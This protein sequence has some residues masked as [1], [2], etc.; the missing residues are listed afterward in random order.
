LTPRGGIVAAAPSRARFGAYRRV[1]L[2]GAIL[3]VVLLALTP[4]AQPELPL[5]TDRALAAA[6][7]TVG[8]EST[9][10]SVPFQLE[11]APSFWGKVFVASPGVSSECNFDGQEPFANYDTCRIEFATE[12]LVRLRARP[13]PGSRFV[14]WDDSRCPRSPTCWLTINQDVP[15]RAIFDP[16]PFRVY[17][18]NL[19]FD[20]FVLSKPA[21]IRC[22]PDC[23]SAFPA[24]TR[25]ILN[26]F[27]PTNVTWGMGCAL[28]QR[29]DTSTTCVA[30]ANSYFVSVGLNGAIPP[31]VPFVLSVRFRVYRTGGGRVTG[32]GINCGGDCRETYAWGE[33]VR[34]TARPASGWRFIRWRG[35]CGRRLQCRVV[36]G[37]IVSIRAAFGRR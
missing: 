27:P 17:T 26:A 32:R 24:G 12:A 2:S 13:S 4:S 1:R 36:P 19:G 25:I 15:I 35:A 5:A 18:A 33:A 11:V 22:P 30:P 14:A 28:V 37:E 10:S 34:L 8:G 3:V 23:S 16:V 29:T 31:E 9:G 21:G 20:Q 7:P 6:A